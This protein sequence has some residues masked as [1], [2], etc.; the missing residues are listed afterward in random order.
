MAK[1]A[2]PMLVAWR[3]RVR[4]VHDVLENMNTNIGAKLR[5][6]HDSSVVYILF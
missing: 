5:F 2:W 3:W 6:I 1:G 4:F